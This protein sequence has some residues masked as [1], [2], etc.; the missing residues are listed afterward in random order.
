MGVLEAI[1]SIVSDLFVM[2]GIP[3]GTSGAIVGVMTGFFNGIW[4]VIEFIGR[5]VEMFQ[6]MSVPV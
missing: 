2:N 6:G 1:M 4:A 3:T 5:M